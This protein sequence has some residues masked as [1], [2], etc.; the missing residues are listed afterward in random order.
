[1]GSEN[2]GFVMALAQMGRRRVL[3]CTADA[4]CHQAARLMAEHAVGSV[5]VV[6][7]DGRPAGIVT[8]RD[9]ALRLVARERPP[10]TPVG[11]VMT[12]EPATISSEG[13]GVDAARQMAVRGCRRLPV[14]DP[15]S[16]ALVGMV[17]LDDLLLGSA[18]TVDQIIRV[19]SHERAEGTAVLDILRRR[20]VA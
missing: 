1:M 18:E 8:D 16:G 17:T 5:V 3:R 19:L 4:P 6:D 7:D 10:G 2:G 12:A 13:S 11:E 9:L 20:Q 15:V 14:V